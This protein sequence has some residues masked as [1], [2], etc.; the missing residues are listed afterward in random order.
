MLQQDK[1]QEKTD[2]KKMT[3]TGIFI[4]ICHQGKVAQVFILIIWNILILLIFRNKFMLI[5]RNSYPVVGTTPHK[6]AQ[7]NLNKLRFLF[8]R[9]KMYILCLIGNVLWQHFSL[10]HHFSVSPTDHY[11][12]F[13]FFALLILFKLF[14][15]KSFKSYLQLQLLHHL[16]IN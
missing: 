7:T 13:Y 8:A 4:F 9:Y 14:C 1:Q 16:R 2:K 15:F 6:T 10:K 11:Y 12:L 5:F 3:Q